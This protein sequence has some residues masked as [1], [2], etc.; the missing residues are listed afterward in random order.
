M[1]KTEESLLKGSGWFE[2]DSTRLSSDLMFAGFSS[3]LESCFRLHFAKT[4]TAFE[5]ISLKVE[6]FLLCVPSIKVSNRLS[7][8]GC[9]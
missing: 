1:H 6:L 7:T 9:S 2:F 4:A 3:C 5:H 8:S